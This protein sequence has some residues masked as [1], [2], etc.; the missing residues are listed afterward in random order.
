MTKGNQKK[1]AAG[2]KTQQ[3]A[4][5]HLL[6]G[7]KVSFDDKDTE[8]KVSDEDLNSRYAKGEMRIVT[9]QARYPLAG[10]LAM[11]KEEVEG[12]PARWS[13]ATSSTPN[14][15][16]GTGGAWSGSRGSSSRS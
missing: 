15:S 2:A 9:E 14:T 10:I 7:E 6:K 5:S 13:R 11:L 1:P 3:A 4:A 16:G 8:K 12:K